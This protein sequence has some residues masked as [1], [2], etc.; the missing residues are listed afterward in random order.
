MK[1]EWNLKL[2]YK[3]PKDP[4]IERDLLSIEKASINFE[5]KYKNK[6]DYLKDEKKLLK[7][8]MD[9]EKLGEET[10]K[11]VL[12]YFGY[13]VDLNSTDKKAEALYT[14]YENL[15]S[16]FHNRVIFFGINLA[17]IDKKNQGIFLKSVAFKKYKYFLKDNFKWCD[18]TL[19]EKEERILKLKSQTSYSM[20]T[21]M[22]QKIYSGLTVQYKNKKLNL[23]ESS[24]LVQRLE[25]HEDRQKLYDLIK[26]KEKEQCLVAEAELNAVV[27]NKKINDELKGFKKPYSSMVLAYE[28]SEETVENLV[29]VVTSNFKLV[30]RFYRIKAKMLKLKKLTMADRVCNVGEIKSKFDFPN[31]VKI[32]KQSFS[33]VKSEFGKIFERF[34]ERGQIDVFPRTGKRG[35]AY[36]SYNYHGDTFVLTNHTGDIDSVRT[37]AHEMGHAI[38]GEFSKKQPYIY[39]GVTA[40]TAEVASTFFE[41]FAFDELYGLVSEK[42]KIVMLHN[43]ISD[44][45]NTVFRQISVFN[46]EVELHKLIREKGYLSHDEIALLMVK[47]TKSCV[48]DIFEMNINDGYSFANWPHLRYYF[49]VY[50]Y[51]F[52]DLV[53]QALYSKYKKDP[54]YLS[55]IEEFLS[56]GRS[57]TPENIFKKIGID[58]TDPKFFQEGIDKIKE[59]VDKLERLVGR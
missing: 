52:G 20:W 59:D 25:K 37:L 55:K 9:Y 44:T 21:S 13:L 19:S 14:K 30:H 26:E 39:N 51:A 17:K 6:T 4:Q 50:S 54:K 41:N 27:I 33:K 24:S 29:K 38:H 3:S 34:I 48:G 43:R 10:S 2:L 8:L 40:S 42:E 49:Y 5:K 22:R 45:I 1:T 31:T 15:L 36:C 12:N 56:A 32:I 16:G 23:T 7:A 57:D 47:H 46:F 35:G 28:N 58:V 11:P 18:Y 53:S